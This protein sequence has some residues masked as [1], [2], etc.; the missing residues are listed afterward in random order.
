MNPARKSTQAPTVHCLTHL[1]EDGCWELDGKP[2]S[3]TEA[4]RLL[5]STRPGV[6]IVVRDRVERILPGA[7]ELERTYGKPN[8]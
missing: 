5:C 7:I 6:I 1:D 8:C 4:E 3:D 2:V